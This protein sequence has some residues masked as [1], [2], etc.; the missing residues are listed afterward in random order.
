M[1]ADDVRAALLKGTALADLSSW[2]KVAVTGAEAER[3]LN[4]LVSAD[5]SGLPSGRS[6]RSLILTPTGRIRAEFTVARLG[7][8]LLLLQDPSQPEAADAVLAPYVLSSDVEL[9]DRTNAL[10][11]FALPGGEWP[12]DTPG[13][14]EPSVT[15]TGADLLVEAGEHDFTLASLSR[16]RTPTSD[17]DLEAWR[18]IVGRP[19]FGVDALPEDLPQEAGLAGAV[20]FDKG[21][22]LGQEAVAKV[23]NL[24]HPRRLV[25]HLEADAALAVGDTVVASG[26]PA[27]TITSAA[28]WSG[29]WLAL[30]R[31]GWEARDAELRTGSG[32]AL[33]RV[34]P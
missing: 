32:A 26:E 29:R 13:C 21:C 27:G 34:T 16:T 10:A 9:V 14:V 31:I 11:L 6:R 19:R 7:D 3:W 30:A 22:Y 23:R 8:D 15:G 2:R 20:A 1:S 28:G 18:V 5:V 4:D 12:G 17:A 33:R 24:G 25:V